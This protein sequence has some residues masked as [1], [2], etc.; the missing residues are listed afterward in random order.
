M[1]VI[2]SDITLGYCPGVCG[3]RTKYRCMFTGGRSSVAEMI[4][5]TSIS[6]KMQCGCYIQITLSLNTLDTTLLLLLPEYMLLQS[7]S[8]SAWVVFGLNILD[9]DEV[10]LIYLSFVLSFFFTCLDVGFLFCCCCCCFFPDS[11]GL[12][13]NRKVTCVCAFG[14]SL[15]HEWL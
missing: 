12:Q 13:I 11:L 15:T 10:F 14:G 2:F 3:R 8:I 7:N 5:V 9:R 1:T 6:N 4:P